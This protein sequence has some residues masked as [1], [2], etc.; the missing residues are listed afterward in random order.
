M[1]RASLREEGEIFGRRC[2]WYQ[3]PRNSCRYGCVRG[4]IIYPDNT[5]D[6]QA[7]DCLNIFTPVLVKGYAGILRADWV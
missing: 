3:S 7:A 2:R 4:S 6:V 5:L 1:L